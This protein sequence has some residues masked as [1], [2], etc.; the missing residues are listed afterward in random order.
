FKTKY[1]RSAL[2][3]LWSFLNP[4]MTMMVLYFVFSTLF[5]S[6][7]KNYPVY[8]LSGL[9]CWNFF[10]EATTMCLQSI[11]GNAPLIT[12]VYVPKYIYPL[13]RAMSSL[14]NFFLAFIPLFVV[15]VITKV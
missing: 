9:I 10:S 3:V 7:V 8:L 13:S 12:K 11:V 5:I 2:G 15:M 6:N 14:V 1:K 4:L